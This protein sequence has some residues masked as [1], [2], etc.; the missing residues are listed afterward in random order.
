MV[1]RIE[2]AVLKKRV[3]TKAKH[4]DLL[5]LVQWAKELL[6][7]PTKTWIIAGALLLAEIVVNVGVI[8]K[9]KCESTAYYYSSNFCCIHG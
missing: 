2:M 7:D 4:F 6:F 8:W 9:I 5:L 1:N 3:K